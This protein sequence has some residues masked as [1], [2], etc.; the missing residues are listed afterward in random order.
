[1]TNQEIHL[2]FFD[3][4]LNEIKPL[5]N[6]TEQ[7]V[8]LLYDF[9]KTYNRDIRDELFV[10]TGYSKLE[11][12]YAI[13]FTDDDL[14]FETNYCEVVI[15]MLL[16]S[17]CAIDDTLIFF[18]DSEKKGTAIIETL[19]WYTPPMIA[20]TPCNAEYYYML[21]GDFMGALATD[22]HTEFCMMT[23]SQNLFLFAANPE[24]IVAYVRRS[25]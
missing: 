22:N 9:L 20:E 8:K 16:Q 5:F 14:E 2:P 18:S 21:L 6:P 13:D 3:L 19:E 25:L 1:M 23:S 7:S 17:Y 4:N 24:Y 12:P 15:P 10:R 11:F